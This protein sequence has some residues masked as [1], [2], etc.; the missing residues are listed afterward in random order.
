MSPILDDILTDEEWIC[1]SV[2]LLLRYM[3]SIIFKFEA[4]V[5]TD[6]LAFSNRSSVLEFSKS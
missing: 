2:S 5:F 4:V 1:V 6:R 3:R